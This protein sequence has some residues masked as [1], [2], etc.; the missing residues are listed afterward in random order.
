MKTKINV[1]HCIFEYYPVFTGHGIYLDRLFSFIDR[2]AFENKMLTCNY[3]KFSAQDEHHN[4]LI[5]RFDF[6]PGGRLSEFRHSFQIVKY[7][8]NNKSSFDVLHLHGHIDIYG[9]IAL[10][11]RVL[12]KKLVMQMVLMGADDPMTIRRKYRL[13][14]LRFYLLLLVDKFVCIS[15]QIVKSAQT[16]GIP[17]NKIAYVPQG[18]DAVHFS[19][20]TQNEKDAMR[21]VLGVGVGVKVVTFVGA[22]I[23]RK[24]V[25]WLIDAWRSIQKEDEHSLLLLVGPYQYS[26][27]DS[28]KDDLDEF[29]AT[30]RRQIDFHH[31]NVEFVGRRDDVDS[32][33]KISDVFVLPSRKEGFGNVII[34]AMA[35]GIPPVVTYMDGVAL[36]TVRHGY[37]GFIANSPSEL[38]L[39]I[40][41]LL[42]DEALNK[43]VGMN[44]RRSV[45]EQFTINNIAKSYESLYLELLSG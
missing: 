7:L 41:Q 8:I 22:V 29:V 15:R 28:N 5:N 30:I 21:L 14:F 19:P 27:E 25:D 33:L 2:D 45:D 44:A 12:G 11:C 6:K 32:F 18:V 9:L 34:E 1:L 42:T 39:Y 13:M 26:D 43:E 36:E 23:R 31:L 24:G 17:S 16:A 37:N 35:C 3:K 20:V 40:K 38:A 10:C 4:V